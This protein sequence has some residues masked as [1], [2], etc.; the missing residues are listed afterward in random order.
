MKNKNS[1]FYLSGLLTLVL[2][3]WGIIHPASFSAVASGSFKLLT[4]NFGW[5]YMMSENIFTV[6]ALVI[7]CSRFGNIRLGPDDSKP[8]IS[9]LSWIAMLF[10][11]GMGI[12]LVFYGAAEPAIHFLNPPMG[13]APESALAAR[14]AMEI[15][16]FHWGLSIWSSYTVIGMGLAY[17]QFRRHCPGQISSLFMPLLGKKGIEGPIGKTIDIVA[18]FATVAGIATSLGLGA[19]QISS[20]L[21]YVFGI[22]K[23]LFVQLVIIAIFTVIYTGTAVFG[24]DKGISKVADW[25][26]YISFF[27][28]AALFVVGPTL[29]IIGSF[30]TGTGDYIHIFVSQAMNISPFEEK[31]GNFLGNWTQ[32]YFAWNITWAP[33]VGSFIARISRGRTL[34][35]FILGVLIIPTIGDFVW[36]SVFGACTL[37]L[38]LTHSLAVAQTIVGDI[39][40]GVFEM[41]SHY[42]LGSLLSIIMTVLVST[43][44]VTSAN[45]G[46]FVLAMFTSNGN[47]NPPK[48]RMAVWGILLALLAV[49]LM[50]TGGLSNL[51]TIS[52]VAAP[53]FAIVAITSCWCLYKALK[54]EEN[55]ENL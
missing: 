44:F 36:F 37:D 23:T 4:H 47:L 14:Q 41:F 2:V 32:Y 30:M 13:A 15:S 8:E 46:T 31:F 49:V 53:P 20:G 26:I 18:T 6:F 34:R 24:I 45:S 28:L 7:A 17:F 1:I 3:I 48:S 33:F 51:M 19:M 21:Q 29:K 10:S 39:S 11:A 38:N 22:P 5:G 12:G 27:I 52:L 9:T 55:G 16:F 42:P 50:L 43:F 25:N 35:Q 40:V 54:A